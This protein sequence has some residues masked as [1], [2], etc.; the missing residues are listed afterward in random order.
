VDFF[1]IGGNSL[2]AIMAASLIKQALDLPHLSTP[3]LLQ[4]ST[5]A[6]MAA[7]LE[8]AAPLQARQQL[9]M[10]AAVNWEDSLRPPSS[11]QQQMYTLA[12][13]DP[14]GHLYNSSAAVQYEGSLSP[15][16][17]QAALDVVIARHECLRSCFEV[18]PDGS[19]MIQVR[20]VL[21]PVHKLCVWV[22]LQ[23]K[24]QGCEGARLNPEPWSYTPL[25]VV[26]RV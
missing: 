2:K 11:G 10:L 6:T 22:I 26:G 16:V 4:H 12:A 3:Q 19:I 9:P 13:M 5:I 20:A 1:R 21:Q 25:P 15:E 23:L 8:T 18:Q 17:L 14:T 24:L 7:F